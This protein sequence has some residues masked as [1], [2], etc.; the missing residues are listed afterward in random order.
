MRRKILSVVLS[1]AMIGSLAACGAKEEAPA[2]PEK[3]EEQTEDTSV[4]EAEDVDLV[5]WCHENGPW[6]KS[7]EAMAQKFMDEHPNYHI[8][9]ESYPM[10]EYMT[11]IQTALTDNTAPDVIALWGGMSAAFV[12]SD[13]LAPVPAD[14]AKVMDEDF[15]APTKGVY[16]KDGVYYGVPMEYNLEYGGMVVNKKLFD[17][18]GLSYPTTWAE[19][20]EVSSKV[21][22]VN[23]DIQEMGGFE[24]LD[25]DALI[26]NFLAMVLQLGGNYLNEDGTVNFNIPEAKTAMEELLSFVKNGECS[27]EHLTAGDYTYNDIYQDK[28]FMS[29]VGTWGI[30]EG[31]GTYGL[32]EGEDFEYVPVPQYGDKMA[33]TSESGWGL[34]VPA[35][36][37]NTDASWEYVSWFTDPENLVDHNIACNQLP[38]RET[39]LTNEKYLAEMSNID[40]ILDI[41]PYGQWRGPLRCSAMNGLFDDE[42]IA[43]VQ[44]E[45]PDV[46]T[47]LSNFTDAVNAECL[48]GYTN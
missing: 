21:G 9:V 29:S 7:Y 13:A 43:L 26:N 41:L 28:G 33:F 44:G 48:L 15:M 46:E 25:G 36:A 39:M 18:E 5:F 30:G 11:K 8:T 22:K 16:Q 37:K 27:L 34:I 17:Q 12:G 42:F 4:E 2:E 24:F 31:T 23:G 35:N 47:A 40:F 32:K 1:L 3:Q 6:I 38:P 10:S 19:L 14:L 45:T 20:K